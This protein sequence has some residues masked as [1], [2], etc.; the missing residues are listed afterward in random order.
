[1][2]DNIATIA[3]ETTDN[4]PLTN[5]PA[6]AAEPA[7]TKPKR[8]L[9]KIGDQLIVAAGDMATMTLEQ[10]KQRLAQ[11]GYP[12]AANATTTTSANTDGDEVITFLPVAGR[13]G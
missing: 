11:S 8:R 6:A 5:P 1:M 3:P 10:L 2:T 13:K 4:D 7:K 12:E 9:L